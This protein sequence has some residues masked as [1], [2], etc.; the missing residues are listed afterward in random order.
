MFAMGSELLI[1]GAFAAI[2]QASGYLVYGFQ[3]LRR[4]I[5]PNAV[6]WLMFAYG[7]TLLLVLE[8]DRDASASV[9]LLPAIC[10]ISSIIVALYCIR[11]TR[12]WWWPEHVL[13]RFS[14]GFDLLLTVAYLSTWLLLLGEAI[15]PG[16]KDIAELFI[17]M[18]WNIGIFT[19]FYPL[20]RQV[21][22]HP[23]T[24]HAL[25]WIVWTTAYA[26]LSYVTIAERGGIDELALYPIIALAIHG[27]IAFWIAF[28]HR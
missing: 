25:P 20:L 26:A 8:W 1:L 18:C 24:E 6:S 14:F 9:L 15:S 28:S 13:D 21:Y 23:H 3:V 27:F 10:A 2:L 5:S 22:T 4:D 11:R 7:T 19:A 16:Q 17:L 12:N